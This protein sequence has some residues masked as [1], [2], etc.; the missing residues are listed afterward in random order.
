MSEY[1]V[2]SKSVPRVDALEKVTGTAKYG[3]DIQLPGMLY[4]KIFRS[5][6]AHAKIL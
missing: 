1:S 5:K 2:V 6:H 3:A 4:G